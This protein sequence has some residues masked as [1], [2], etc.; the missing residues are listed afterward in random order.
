MVPLVT[1]RLLQE[2]FPCQDAPVLPVNHTGGDAPNFVQGYL[3][4]MS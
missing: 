1:G 4:G 2:H 3:Y